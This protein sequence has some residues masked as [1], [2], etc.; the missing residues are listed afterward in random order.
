MFS[1]N[2]GKVT[3]VGLTSYGQGCADP[4]YA[5]VYSRVSTFASWIR[6]EQSKPEFD[7]RIEAEVTR[8]EVEVY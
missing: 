8:T 7:A 4:N 1:E 6:A 2:N 3:L 5:G